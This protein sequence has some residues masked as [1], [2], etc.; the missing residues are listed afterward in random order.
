MDFESIGTADMSLL[1]QKSKMVVATASGSALYQYLACFS[2][3]LAPV[4]SG[5]H[6]G[7]PSPT[8]PRLLA[9]DS[10][11]PINEDQGFWLATM[12]LFGGF[13][14]SFTNPL[15][16]DK[17]GRHKMILLTSG[18]YLMAW[19]MIYF[20]R[21]VP[22]MYIAR[23]IAG[24]SDGWS[25]SSVPM[26]TG[27]VSDANKRG[28]FAS[29]TSIS[30]IFGIL[31]V[32][33]VGSYLSIQHTAIVGGAI[34][35]LLILTFMW[36]PESPYYYIVK[37]NLEGARRSLKIL[38]GLS[39]VDVETELNR[40]D[41]AVKAD[42]TKARIN[43]L[44]LFTLKRNRKAVLI[45]MLCRG[46]QQFSGNSAISF[47]AQNIFNTSGDFMSAKLASNLFF[48]TQL[49]V[50]ILASTVVDKIGRRPLILISVAG[51]GITLMVEGIYFYLQTVIDVSS[52]AMVPVIA[53]LVYIIFFSIGLQGIPIIILS[54]V[55]NADIK[56][57]ALGFAEIYF[58]IIATATSKFFQ[59]TRD[60]YGMHVPFISF[61]TI[62]AIAVVLI[63][64]MVPETKGKTLE[65]IQ[66]YFKGVKHTKSTRECSNS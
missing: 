10:L 55:F 3:I 17:I 36:M 20:A 1:E 41:K 18:P 38:R 62:C 56:S 30:F 65:E 66:D 44:H 43:P 25:F 11:I 59:V 49:V 34:P 24:I 47:Y 29:W 51:V 12:P 46:T 52:F 60:H 14:G 50:T 5:F 35:V 13:V 33:F 54:E 63:F 26:Y 9:E 37:N 45:M 8:L 2:A 23:F 32:N 42:L 19:I 61:S 40:I 6:Y 4:S 58:A 22:M 48:L 21:N 15:L 31:G 64:I 28:M 7:W 53:L 39:D 27:E 57:I 16:V